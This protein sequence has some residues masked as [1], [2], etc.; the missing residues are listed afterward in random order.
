[1][2]IPE[3]GRRAKFWAG[4]PAGPLAPHHRALRPASQSTI[5]SN[6]TLVGLVLT[7]VRMV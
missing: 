6:A 2:G 4:S 3:S 5:A 7:V 1:M